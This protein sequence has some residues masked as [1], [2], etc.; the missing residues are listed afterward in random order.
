MLVLTAAPE[1]AAR[2]WTKK[3]A[4]GVH[5]TSIRK[6]HPK[7]QAR[8]VSIDPSRRFT[9]HPVLATGELPGLERTSTIARRRH[10]VVAVNGDYARPSGRPVFTFAQNGHLMQTPLLW[11]RN[12]ALS[13]GGN[14]AYIGHP[15]VRA[16][17]EGVT[18]SPVPID[19]VNEGP[20]GWFQLALNTVAGG[21]LERPAKRTCSARL[22]PVGLP[23]LVP[24]SVAISIEHRVDRVV[25][26]YRPLNLLGGRG[27]VLSAKRGSPRAKQL[28]KLH[29]G[30]HP[31][32]R[33]SLG[34]ENVKETIGG[35]PTLIENGRIVVKPSNL[36]FF[37]KAPRTAVAYTRNK[38]VLLVT[39]DGRHK[40][41]SRGITPVGLARLL[42]RYGAKWALNLDGGGS[43]TMVVRGKIINR[44][45]DGRERAVSSALVVVPRGTSTKTTVGSSASTNAVSKTWKRIAADPASTGGLAYSMEKKK[46]RLSPG[47]ERAAREFSRAA[48]RN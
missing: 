13:S 15:H 44:P 37:R 16:W 45:S 23:H 21:S 31:S 46:E 20:P 40:R 22:I 2:S 43:T 34:W 32:L 3:L 36:P 28:M 19:R 24:G 17:L 18:L 42:R 9:I 10:A 48:R 33:W 26:R 14:H 25:C 12:F 1:A 30:M 47:L 38:R 6:W 41:Y 7:L 5:L 39:V 8:I 27:V 29:Q 35:N 4:T 11:G